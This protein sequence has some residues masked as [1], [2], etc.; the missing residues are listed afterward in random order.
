MST[1]APGSADAAYT[2]LPDAPDP[3]VAAHSVVP[4]AL[5]VEE[6]DAPDEEDLPLPPVALDSRVRWIMFTLGAAVLAPWN[7][8]SSR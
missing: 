1:V 3:A 7:G 5:D 2:T 4:S 8:S 6:Q